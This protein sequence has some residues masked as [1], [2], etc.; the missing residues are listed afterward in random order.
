MAPALLTEQGHHQLLSLVQRQE[1]TCSRA[2]A[3]P[4][5]AGMVQVGYV[6]L[7]PHMHPKNLSQ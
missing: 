2:C 5:A 1:G 7:H 6:L 3:A 4:L